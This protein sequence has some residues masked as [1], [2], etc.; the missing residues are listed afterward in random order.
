M[1][2]WGSEAERR[3]FA[4]AGTWLL[5]LLAIFGAVFL[6]AGI[7]GV[8][9]ESRAVGVF[10]ARVVS[11]AGPSLHTVT[12]RGPDGLKRV[13][14]AK[15]GR[16]QI[17]STIEVRYWPGGHRIEAATPTY[18]LL[19]VAG[20]LMVLIGGGGAGYRAARARRRR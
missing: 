11:E 9:D 8:V 3:L 17:G 19:V 7:Q 6:V 12:V 5:L 4:T 16:R 10:P 20:S 18:R 1:E 2:D 13:N 14:V 15:Y